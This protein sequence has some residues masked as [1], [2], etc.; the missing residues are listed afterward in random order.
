MHKIKSF[1]YSLIL[2]RL[3]ELSISG[4]WSYAFAVACTAVTIASFGGRTYQVTDVKN[5]LTTYTYVKAR[6]LTVSLML[7]IMLIFTAL[8]GF[9]LK[10]SEFLTNWSLWIGWNDYS[11]PSSIC[12]LKKY[13]LS[14]KHQRGKKAIRHGPHP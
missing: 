11:K 14:I 12:P 13:L 6:Y 5:E 1:V 2:V 9:N 3:C 8:K 7:G 4:V 10:Q